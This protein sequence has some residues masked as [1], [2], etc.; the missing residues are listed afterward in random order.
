MIVNSWSAECFCGNIDPCFSVFFNE[1]GI[2]TIEILSAKALVKTHDS[3]VFGYTFIKS[4]NT[5]GLFILKSMRPVAGVFMPSNRWYLYLRK[6]PPLCDAEICAH[7]YTGKWYWFEPRLPC[8]KYR[9]CFS[10]RVAQVSRW[11][12]TS[13]LSLLSVIYSTKAC[14]TFSLISEIK[15]QAVHLLKPN[16]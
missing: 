8:D 7:I 13:A 10:G 9:R 4:R 11:D 12:V 3:M 16:N 1:F 5:E 15:F 14:Q 2:L 6:H